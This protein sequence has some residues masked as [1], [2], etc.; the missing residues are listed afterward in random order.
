VGL[1]EWVPHEGE[2]DAVRRLV[3]RVV[4]DFGRLDI[5]V[6]A[7]RA[8]AQE[9][10]GS[11]DGAARGEGCSVLSPQSSVLSGGL[12]RG[13][14]WAALVASLARAAGPFL[15]KSRPLGHLIVLAGGGPASPALDKP[16]SLRE[17]VE[18]IA[19]EWKAIRSRARITMVPLEGPVSPAREED[20]PQDAREEALAPPEEAARL[21]LRCIGQPCGE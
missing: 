3:E 7:T 9:D 16:D 2:A 18:T 17:K 11:D 6:V 4:E 10:T 20:S 15:R 1:E 5:V 21:V 12:A 19:R 8:P 13:E 14:G